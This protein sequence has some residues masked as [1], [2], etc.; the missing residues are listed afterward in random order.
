MICKAFEDR[1]SLLS[2]GSYTVLFGLLYSADS[3]QQPRHEIFIVYPTRE[4]YFH[5]QI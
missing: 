3:S 5:I 2:V 1:F 4:P